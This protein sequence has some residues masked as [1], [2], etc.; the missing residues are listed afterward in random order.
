MF[1]RVE[2][3]YESLNFSQPLNLDN[4][5]KGISLL[6]EATV[7]LDV[8]KETALRKLAELTQP[9]K[10]GCL[11]KAKTAV[12]ESAQKI[13]KRFAHWDEDDDDDDDDEEEEEEHNHHHHHHHPHHLPSPRKLREIKKVL[14]DIK[15]INFKISHFEAGFIGE[16]LPGREWYAHTGTAP[17]RWSVL[18]NSPKRLSL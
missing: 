3:I 6:Q 15:Q 9:R 17:G 1:F 7:A 10:E 11:W 16:G 5:S 13:Q 18:F 2:Y 12:K 14:E 4:L 8:Q